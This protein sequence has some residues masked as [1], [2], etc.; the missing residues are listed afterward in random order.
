MNILVQFYNF[1]IVIP[2]PILIN[3]TFINFHL[4]YLVIF[5]FASG[6]GDFI[7]GPSDFDGICPYESYLYVATDA[8]KFPGTE[9]CCCGSSCCWDR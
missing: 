9:Y 2:V 7:S 4:Q 1:L 3:S 5:F 6:S 8:D